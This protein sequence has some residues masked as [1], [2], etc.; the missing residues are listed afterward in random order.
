M[1]LKFDEVFLPIIKMTMLRSV[2]A[3]VA[4]QDLNLQQMDMKMMF[5][6]DT[7]HEEVYMQQPPGYEHRDKSLVCRLDKALYGLKQAPN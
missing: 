6:H 1:G 7:L 5:L 3:M 4:I 2:L